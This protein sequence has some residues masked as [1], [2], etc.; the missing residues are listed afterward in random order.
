[1]LNDCSFGLHLLSPVPQHGLEQQE[2][3]CSFHN[4][5]P[6]PCFDACALKTIV[7]NGVITA[8]E[9]DCQS[10]Y[11]N[12]KICMRG[13]QS[14]LPVY[15]PDRI[16]YPMLQVG[17]CSDNWRRISWDEAMEL[18]AEKILE[19]SAVD[20]SLLSLGF[21]QPQAAMG[22]GR[23]MPLNLMHSL[24]YFTQFVYTSQMPS[25]ITA[26]YMG[27]GGAKSNDPED[28]CE[29]GFIVL[30]GAN[31]ADSA[32]HSMQFIKQAQKNGATVVCIDPRYTETAK[33]AD[34][35]WKITPGGDKALA[36]LLARSIIDQD[37]YD[38]DFVKKN[39]LGF[40]D[41]REAVA[42]IEQLQ[43]GLDCGIPMAQ[44]NQVA[45]LF[46]SNKPATI[47]IGNGFG[48]SG[49]DVETIR[50]IDALVALTGN[51]GRVGGGSRYAHQQTA[52]EDFHSFSIKVP[53]A[54]RPYTLNKAE[55]ELFPILDQHGASVLHGNRPAIA[56]KFAREVLT[57]Q[58]P[59]LRMVWIDHCDPFSQTFDRQ[60]TIRA[61]D[62]LDLIVVV[63]SFFSESVRNA[64]LV[65]PATTFFE[66]YGTT[67][68][69]WNY[70]ININ[71]QAVQPMHE[72]KSHLEIAALL[73]KTMNKKCEGSCTFPGP[74]SALEH[75]RERMRLLTEKHG[76][77]F[78]A[79]FKINAP[80]PWSD[81]K[82]DTP[83]GCFEFCAN[84]GSGLATS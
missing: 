68:S 31:P 26:Q 33:H 14:F 38:R 53:E 82:F 62:K 49:L 6:E 9:G 66:E 60:R 45:H 73:S 74:A 83:S 29:S 3:I 72:A 64:D 51:F 44:I 10:S 65:L 55:Q 52:H 81:Y 50:C 5:C 43:A 30:W 59:E 71:E 37:L 34:I 41:F 20:D 40:T 54:A 63:D 61:R 18:V 32:S 7:Q 48:N 25:A 78:S 21:I 12:G 39:C 75:A 76:A 13:H 69:Y 19:L 80:T 56:Q 57:L 46:A 67:S 58:E 2:A 84:P 77:V 17:R 79:P 24:G 42:K 47:W 15:S 28:L 35:Y 4:A 27:L 23:K 16:K 70:W 8:V 36:L 22:N 11:T 1:M